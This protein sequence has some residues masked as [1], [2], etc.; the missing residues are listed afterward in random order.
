MGMSAFYKRNEW[1]PEPVIH[2][3]ALCVSDEVFNP[4]TGN[5]MDIHKADF[6]Y[7]V[8]GINFFCLIVS[9]FFFWLLETRSN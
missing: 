8:M 2:A 7:I 6:M 1:L 4:F 3:T 5:K 9:I